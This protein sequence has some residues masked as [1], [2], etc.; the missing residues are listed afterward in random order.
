[1]MTTEYLLAAPISIALGCAAGIICAFEN[2][3]VEKLRCPYTLI[4]VPVAACIKT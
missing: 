1:M 2:Y 4:V 3:P